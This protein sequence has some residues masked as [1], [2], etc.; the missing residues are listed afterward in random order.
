MIKR[1]LEISSEPY[2][3]SAR[4]D[5]LILRAGDAAPAASVPCEDLGIVIVDHP[6]V[7]YSHHALATL[8]KAGAA[9]VVCGGNHL[10]VGLYLPLGDH[11]EI[12]SRVRAQ[13]AAPLPLRKRLWKQLVQAKIRAQAFNLPSGDPV[14]S[15]LI[16]LISQ[17][18]SGDP[19]NVEAQAAKLYWQA[20]WPDSE[21]RRRPDGDDAVNA[22]LNYGYAVIRAAVGRAIVAA[23]LIPAV[24]LHHRHRANPFCLADDLMEPLR[25]RVDRVVGE[26]LQSGHVELDRRAKAG[27]IGILQETTEVAGQTGPLMVGLHRVAA[28]LVR[29]F[30]K[31]GSRLALP[32][33]VSEGEPCT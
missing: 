24:G 25:P 16:A 26:L 10:P 22:L 15:R 5:Q 8:A 3:V 13:V 28:S 4:L 18:R 7:S 2:H 32:S 33:P 1:I 6:Q 14:R 31:E 30:R 20:L 17:V 23:G 19:G 12:A 27:L 9:V 21:F 29:C 11:S